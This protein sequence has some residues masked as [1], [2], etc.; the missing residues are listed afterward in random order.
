MPPNCNLVTSISPVMKSP[1]KKTDTSAI[2]RDSVA[3]R[4]CSP[5]LCEEDNVRPEQI[6]VVI[7]ELNIKNVPCERSMTNPRSTMSSRMTNRSSMSSRMSNLRMKNSGMFKS[8][9]RAGSS[10]KTNSSGGS[11]SIVSSSRGSLDSLNSSEDSEHDIKAPNVFLDSRAMLESMGDRPSSHELANV[12]AV[13]ANE[14]IEECLSADVSVLDRKK[15][16]SIPQYARKDLLVGQHLG[17]GSFSDAFEVIVTVVEEEEAPTLES[18]GTVREDLDKLIEAK[19]RGASLADGDGDFGNGDELDEHVDAMFSS[20]P[21]GATNVIHEEDDKQPRQDEGDELDKQIEAMFSPS[22]KGALNILNED[23]SKKPK[24]DAAE[25]PKEFQSQRLNSQRMRHTNNLGV[26]MSGISSRK[27]ARKVVMAMKCLHP[28]I[29]SNAE[30]FMIGVEDLVHE[31]AMLASLDHPHIVKLHGRPGGCASN[32]FR[33]SDG[34]FILLDRLLKDTLDE[35]INHWKQT[36]GYKAQPSRIQIKTACSIADA[37]SYLHSKNI[38][39][40]DLKP[41][42]VGFDSSGVLKL[43]DFGFAIGIGVN[44]E[45]TDESHLLYDRCGT[46]RY[47]APEVGL[48]SGYGLPADVYSFGILLWEICAL[49]KPFGHVKSVDEFH[50]TVFR[51][52]SRPKLGKHWPHNLKDVISNCWSSFPLERPSMSHVKSMLAAHDREL[53]MQ[54]NDGRDNLRK[55]SAFRRFTG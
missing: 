54:K 2:D 42:N 1:P 19:F 16:E 39:F 32:S 14:Y 38:V 44:S 7:Q 8:F 18:L 41:A 49:K 11:D 40:R 34:Y 10:R 23:D 6:Q 47:M 50:K 37:M 53:S 36:S 30:Q 46:P 21:K 24:Q 15:W 17:R 29:R 25:K 28:Q 51:K 33:L 27:K 22:S 55:S 43:F 20:S 35:R 48:E 4:S 9:T 5:S 31:T 13:R 26:S 52:G 12:A 45:E 3:T